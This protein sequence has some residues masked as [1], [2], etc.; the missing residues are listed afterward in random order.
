MPGSPSQDQKT[1]PQDESYETIY[2]LGGTQDSLVLKYHAAVD[3]YKNGQAKKLMIASAEG[4]TEYSRY[5]GRNLTNDE[6]TVNQLISLGV[7]CQDIIFIRLLNGYFGTLK[8]AETVK[9]VAIEKGIKRLLLVCSAYHAKRV[10]SIFSAILENSGVE[11]NIRTVDEQVGN[12]VL[13]YEYLKLIFYNNILIP[14]ERY[15]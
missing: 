6:W 12:S 9:K 13:F 3:I 2:I 7:K 4:I 15:F 1:E 11:I 8:E 10:K 5:L 14:L